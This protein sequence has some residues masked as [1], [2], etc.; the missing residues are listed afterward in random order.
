MRLV[1]FDKSGGD[2]IGR[3]TVGVRRDGAIVDLSVAAP[4][5]PG[6]WPAIFA[7]G[8]MDRV[9]EAARRAGEDA[10]VAEADLRLMVPIPRPPKILC[11]GL[12]YRSHAEETNMAIPDYPIVFTRYATSMVAHGAPLI[13]PASSEQFDFEAELVAIIG[14]GGRHIPK[15]RALDHV[16]GYSIF[17]EGSVRDYQRKS[18]QWAMGKNFDDSGSFGPDIV[19]ADELPPGAAGLRIQCRL[20]GE[21]MQDSDIDDL[22]FDVATLVTELSAVMTLEPGDIIVTGTPPG[23]GFVRKP[24][25]FMKSGDVCEVEIEGIGILRNSVADEGHA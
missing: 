7:S 10:V 14:T 3:P 1:T 13:R 6:D 15:E 12:N 4:E 5:L 18:S 22:I 17:N 25:L 16:V 11:I 23:V 9:A 20:N 21:T 2:K 24:P 19:T 8:S